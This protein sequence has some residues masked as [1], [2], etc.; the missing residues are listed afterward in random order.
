MTLLLAD[1]RPIDESEVEPEQDHQP[2]VSP[3]YGKA[4]GCEEAAQIERISRI[5][6]WSGCRQGLILRQMSRGPSAQQE[7]E[8]RDGQA[9]NETGVCRPGEDQIDS[10]DYES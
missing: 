2:D 10:G 3:R 4:S 7:A 8:E 1:Y 5:R 9:E 6:K